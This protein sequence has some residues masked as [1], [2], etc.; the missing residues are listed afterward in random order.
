M[1]TAL[2]DTTK[3]FL[4]VMEEKPEVDQEEEKDE[5]ISALYLDPRFQA[6]QEYIN[7]MIA[8]LENLEG[9]I[10]EHDSP[11][12]IGFRYM[13]ARVTKSYLATIRDLPEVIANAERTESAE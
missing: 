4:K 8:H 10:E 5:L 11:E 6:L 7:S 3:V 9:V 13:I 2:H 1:E 12:V